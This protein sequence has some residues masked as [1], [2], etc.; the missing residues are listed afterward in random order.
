MELRYGYSNANVIAEIDR[1]PLRKK[2][3]ELGSSELVE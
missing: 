2:V 3:L 1:L